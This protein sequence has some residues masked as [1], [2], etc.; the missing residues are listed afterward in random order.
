MAVEVYKCDLTGDLLLIML[1]HETRMMT[2]RH[3]VQPLD[4]MQDE[5]FDRDTLQDMNEDKIYLDGGDED[6]PDRESLPVVCHFLVS[7]RHMILASSVFKAMLDGDFK[8]GLKLHAMGELEISLPD[9]DPHTF[10]ILLDIIHG[11][12]RNV[13][14]QISLPRLAKL[15]ILVDKY[16]ILERVEIFSDMWIDDIQNGGHGLPVTFGP[17]ILPWLSV[18][19]VFGKENIFQQ[20]TEILEREGDSDMGGES[21]QELPIP[22]LIIGKHTLNGCHCLQLTFAS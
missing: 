19:W 22:D 12:N 4:G 7:S 16:Q 6:E 17:D 2:L 10:S 18:S 15:A 1:R 20:V 21:I 11:H 13:P 3:T 5:I 8:E 14:R 9:D